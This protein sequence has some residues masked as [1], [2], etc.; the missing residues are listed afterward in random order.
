MAH[1]APA[2]GAFHDPPPAA[3]SDRGNIDAM[4]GTLPAVSVIVVT[5]NAR[6]FVCACLEALVAQDYPRLQV[7]VVDNASSDGTADLVRRRFPS[8]TVLDSG[9]NGGY[10]A[11]NN[12]GARIAEGNVLAFLNPDTVPE[13]DWLPELVRGMRTH[14]SRWATSKIVLLADP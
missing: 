13:P 7:I 8:V 14:G 11:G 3:T 2:R 10:G 9:H 5:Y 6:P 1:Q 12:L 4:A